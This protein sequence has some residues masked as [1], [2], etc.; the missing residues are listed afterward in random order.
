MPDSTTYTIG[1]QGAMRHA[2]EDLA[3]G[4][5]AETAIGAAGYFVIRMNQIKLAGLQTATGPRL[6]L[7]GRLRYMATL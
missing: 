5:V 4:F 3:S 1:E 7:E 2:V 6:T